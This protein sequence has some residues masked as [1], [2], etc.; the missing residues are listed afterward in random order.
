MNI[1]ATFLP[2]VPHRLG[3][4]IRTITPFLSVK[5]VWD[6][7]FQCHSLEKSDFLALLPLSVGFMSSWRVGRKL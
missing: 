2:D 7:N 4:I 6:I 1:A 3:L 5:Q